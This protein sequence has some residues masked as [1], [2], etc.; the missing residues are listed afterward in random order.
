MTEQKINIDKNF[1]DAKIFEQ[2]LPQITSLIS[3][4]DPVIT[5]LSNFSAVLKDSFSKISWVG[6]Y[7][8]KNNSLYLG[9]FQG[10]TACT[11]IKI[12]A[13]VCG[14]CA[15]E[16]KAII[17]D[18]VNEF[19]EHIACDSDSKSEIVLPL[20]F[21]NKL[22]GILDLDS[23]NLSAFDKTDEIYLTKIVNILVSKINFTNFVLS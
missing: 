12:G 11:Q 20:I 13:G 16:K 17:V 1:S 4:D 7:L 18:N 21:K 8:L 3:S 9:P 5:N 19:P 14:I 15:V 22:I 2:L 23:Y 6:F 10:K